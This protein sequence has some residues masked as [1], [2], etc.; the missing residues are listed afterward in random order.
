MAEPPR[1]TR[2]PGTSVLV[3]AVLLI[4]I[5]MPLLVPVYAKEEPALGG[6]PFFF[7]FQF[8]LIPVTAVLTFMCYRIISRQKAR[9]RQ[10]RGR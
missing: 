3:G 6:V 9:E 8:L 1:E 4:T 5:L 10:E 7:W 2:N